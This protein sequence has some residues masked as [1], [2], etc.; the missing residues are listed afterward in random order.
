MST[1][2]KRKN[3]IMKSHNFVRSYLLTA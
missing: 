2:Y 3:L 1:V